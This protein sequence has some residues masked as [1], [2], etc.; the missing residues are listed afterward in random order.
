MFSL[1]VV[2]NVVSTCEDNVECL[3]KGDILGYNCK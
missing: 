3:L 1:A 2:L